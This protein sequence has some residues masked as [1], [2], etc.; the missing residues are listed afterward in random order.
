MSIKKED[1]K[2]PEPEQIKALRK[3]YQ[4]F[5]GVGITIAQMDCADFVHSTKRAWQMWEGGKR[6]MNL[7]YWELINIKIKKEMKQ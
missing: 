6:S 3:S 2:H 4:D 1:L 5:K 7:A